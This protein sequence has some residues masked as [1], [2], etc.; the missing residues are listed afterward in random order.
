M[1]DPAVVRR[2]RRLL[3]QAA[4][5]AATD[6]QRQ[7][8]ALFAKTFDVPATLYEFTAAERIPRAGM[9]GFRQ[10]VEQHVL[11]DPLTCYGAGSQPAGL[12]KQIQAAC[13]AATAG[14]KRIIDD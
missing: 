12:R 5:Q 13:D 1:E 2:C 10:R 6:P 4:E 14:G 3:E 8:I 9:N 11:P 7:R